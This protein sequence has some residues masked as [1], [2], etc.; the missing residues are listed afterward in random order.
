MCD[1]MQWPLLSWDAMEASDF[2]LVKKVCTKVTLTRSPITIE[3]SP[4]RAGYH[5]PGKAPGHVTYPTT[6]S[7]A[8]TVCGI[9]INFCRHPPA[10]PQSGPFRIEGFIAG[11]VASKSEG[12]RVKDWLHAVDQTVVYQ[13]SVEEVMAL[14]RGSLGSTVDIYTTRDPETSADADAYMHKSF[15]SPSPT[16]GYLMKPAETMAPLEEAALEACVQPSRNSVTSTGSGPGSK[17]DSLDFSSDICHHHR[18]RRICKECGFTGFN[19]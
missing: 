16:M 4:Q 13:L 6:G 10:N 15:A 1:K 3:S 17:K 11:G 19:V 18:I 14:I 12:I 5:L 8:E 9:G 7:R 2:D